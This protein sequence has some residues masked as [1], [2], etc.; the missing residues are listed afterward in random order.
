MTAPNHTSLSPTMKILV[1]TAAF[2]VLIA[3]LKAAQAILVP[4]LLACF[5]AIICAPSLFWLRNRGLPTG[6]ALFAVIIGI[7]IFGLLVSLLVGSSLTD[8]TREMP[9]YQTRLEEKT[10]QLIGILGA[11]GMDVPDREL[12]ALIDPGATMRF[13]AKIFSA[14][15][16]MLSNTFLILL[17][18]I[19]ILLEA[20]GFRGKVLRAFR[21]PE[22]SLE[23]FDLFLQSVNRYMVIKTWVSLATGGLIALWLAIL[24]VDY[25]LLWGLLAFLLNYVPNIGSIIAAVPAVLLA[26]IQLGGPTALLAALGYVA[27]NIILGNVIEPRFMGQG[28]GLSTLIV[29]LSLVFWG[30]VLGPVGMLLSIPLT[31]TVKIGLAGREETRWLGILMGTQSAEEL[32]GTAGETATHKVPE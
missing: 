7:G 4:F 5:I 11:L 17:T 3:G 29:F 15:G 6:L 21:R 19:F 25:P 13:T 32:P 26:L 20:A 23:Q 28:L 2:F 30:W 18:V 1:A 22:S 16:N 27:V 31:M 14:L 8:F 10:G 9:L 12:T 24:G